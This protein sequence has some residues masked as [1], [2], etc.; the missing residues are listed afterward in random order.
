MKSRKDKF[1][2]AFDNLS[3]KEKLNIGMAYW[4]KYDPTNVWRPMSEFN[5]FFKDVKPIKLACMLQ[6]THFDPM[7]DYFRFDGASCWS[8][9]SIDILDYIDVDEIYEHEDLWSDVIDLPNDNDDDDNYD[10]IFLKM[11]F[12]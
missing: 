4:K 11:Y 2:E 5:S 8:G 6:S 3:F 10:L 12:I 9:Y 7:C 1:K